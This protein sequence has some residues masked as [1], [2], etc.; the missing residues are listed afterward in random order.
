E[1][2]AAADAQRQSVELSDGAVATVMWS[3]ELGRS[4]VLA[5]G[6]S[7]LPDGKVYEA[8][9]IDGEGAV[10]AGTFTAAA[11]GTSWHVLDG[12][13]KAG[14]TVGVTVEPAGGSTAPTS[15]PILVVQSA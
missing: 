12:A 4:A 9:Y 8:W 14:D 2:T 13:M 3:N 11:S 1:L 6:L 7:A 5:D 10:P 15:D